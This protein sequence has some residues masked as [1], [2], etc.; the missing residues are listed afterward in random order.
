MKVVIVSK[1]NPWSKN[2]VQKLKKQN[3]ETVWLKEITKEKLAHHN[4]D[5]VFF[6]HWSEIV[7][8]DIYDSFRCVVVHTGNLPQHRGG[9]PIQNQILRGVK[10]SNVN[11][12]TMEKE[13]DSGKIYCKQEI[14]L[15]GA[16]LEIWLLIS[17]VTAKLITDCV[18]KR[19]VPKEQKKL[20]IAQPFSR[21][22]KQPVDF[23]S[24][25]AI[26]GIYDQIRMMDA[27]GYPQAYIEA[28]KYK[29]EF[30]RANVKNGVILADVKISKK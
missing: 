21:R 25:T 23:N 22:V 12:L 15:Q 19:L 7:K 5:W 17:E 18:Q 27:H 26:E 10:I 11:L 28:G 13:V 4:P 3:F 20:D 24:P 6:F 29:I 9:S 1:D 30:S 8:R 14:S 2:L 16:L